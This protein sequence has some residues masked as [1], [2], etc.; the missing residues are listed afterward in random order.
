MRWERSTVVRA[1]GAAAVA[2]ATGGCTGVDDRGAGDPRGE[3]G[4]KTGRSAQR[5]EAMAQRH[6][7]AGGS[8]HAL[9]VRQNGTVWAWGSNTYNQVYDKTDTQ[10]LFPVQVTSL[11]DVVSVAA[12]ALHSLALK[13]DGSVWAWGYN[14]YGAL[15]DGMFASHTSPVQ[16]GSLTGVTTAVAAG[17]YHSVALESDG[18]VWTWGYNQYGQLG[19]NSTTTVASPVQVQDE[20][21]DNLTAVV[22]IDAGAYHTLALTSDGRVLAWGWNGYGQ[23]GNGTIANNQLQ[24]TQVATLTD[25]VA[26][27]AGYYHSVA[28]KSDGTVVS[29]GMGSFGQLGNG[30]LSGQPLPVPVSS[31]AGVKSIAA[32]ALHTMALRSDGTVAAWGYGGYGE[33]GNGAGTTSP[34]PVDIPGL[35]GVEEIACGDDF[36]LSALSAGGQIMSWGYNPYGELG[37]GSTTSSLSP[38][39]A[40]ALSGVVAASGGDD[41]TVAVKWDGTVWAWGKNDYGQIGDGTKITRLTP[42]QVRASAAP[43]AMLTNVQQVAAGSSHTL[44]L[45]SDGTVW[46]WGQNAAEQLGDGTGVDQLYPV[47]VKVD[48]ATFLT[49]IVAIAAGDFHSLALRS[50]GK[51]FA[52]GENSNKQLC[53]ADGSIGQQPYAKE[54]AY[55]DNA[56]GI[57]GGGNHSLVLF[58]DG[59]VYGCGSREKGQLGDGVIGAATDTISQMGVINAVSVAAGVSYSLVLLDNGT[60]YTCGDNGAGQLG[61]GVV[62]QDHLQSEFPVPVMVDSSNMLRG[63]VSIAAAWAIG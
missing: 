56:T 24:A 12:G 40:A 62:D 43:G 27:G 49:G 15:G 18:T 36:S 57:A 60:V 59:T 34:V 51:V 23:V 2:L 22:A 19:N 14:G 55:V 31:L 11:T 53:R 9:A 37:N 17:L 29:W 7:L 44:A 50:D 33:L 16:V 20:Y 21:G 6:R 61:I 52:W 63:V 48:A 25:A 13:A 32:G 46:S 30:A 3:A 5:L 58:A 47:Q 1:I 10:L 35:S 28:L 26:I 38:T 45:K 42:V 41:H 54:M 8:H 39:Q 4:E